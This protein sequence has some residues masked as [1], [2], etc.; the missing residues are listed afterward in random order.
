[1][2]EKYRC[3]FNSGTDCPVKNE[4]GGPSLKPEILAEFCKACVEFQKLQFEKE[5]AAN[6]K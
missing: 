6:L 3:I 2:T 4:Y 1:M 5:K